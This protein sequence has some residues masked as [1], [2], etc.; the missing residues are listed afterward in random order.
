MKIVIEIVRWVYLLLTSGIIFLFFCLLLDLFCLTFFGWNPLIGPWPIFSGTISAIYYG[1]ILM[2]LTLILSLG[3]IARIM[4]GKRNLI[5]IEVLF[6]R[7]A[8]H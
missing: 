3:G 8:E 1:D 6:G 7:Q 2:V 4:V 5:F